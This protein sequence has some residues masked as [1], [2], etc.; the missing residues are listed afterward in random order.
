M[1]DRM[2]FL[3]QL[4]GKRLLIKFLRIGKE[5]IIEGCLIVSY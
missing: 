3:L 5:L 2:N 4:T 1:W